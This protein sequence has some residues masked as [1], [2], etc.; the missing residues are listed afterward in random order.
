MAA[1]ACEYFVVD[2]AAVACEVDV[3]RQPIRKINMRSGS[4]ARAILWDE[5]L[6]LRLSEPLVC[7]GWQLV[8]APSWFKYYCC[9]D[10]L[11]PDDEAL[12][13]RCCIYITSATPSLLRSSGRQAISDASMLGISSG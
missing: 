9:A 5:T 13:Q 4:R 3:S 12:P 6:C 2:Q 1:F 11:C 8:D 10:L 7:S